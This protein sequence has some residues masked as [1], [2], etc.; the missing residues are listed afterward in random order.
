MTV[1]SLT[2]LDDAIVASP[3]EIMAKGPDTHSEATLGGEPA[4]IESAD[5]SG[6]QAW[7][8]PT[9]YAVYTIHD[10]RAV[11]LMFDHWAIVM[12][13]LPRSVLD[14]IVASFRFLDEPVER[15]P[16][17]DTVAGAVAGCKRSG[18]IHGS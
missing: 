4:H 14:Q 15:K 7:G 1:A 8:A 17:A 10:G 11:V 5:F 12:D 9:Y 18:A 13:I 3:N 2:D 6:G 16:I